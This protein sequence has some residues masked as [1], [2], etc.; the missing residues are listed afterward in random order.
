[1]FSVELDIFSGRPNPRWILS[2]AEEKELVN[3][4]L[5]DPAS[6]LPDTLGQARLGYRGFIVRVHDSQSATYQGALK[7]GVQVPLIF[8]IG[9]PAQ[10]LEGAHW[11][12]STAEKSIGKTD[13]TALEAAEA[14]LARA[15]DSALVQPPDPSQPGVPQ[16][17][18][19]QPRGA[20]QCCLYNYLTGTDYGFW[21][22]NWTYQHANNCYN[23][24]A[25]YR[26]GDLNVGFAQPGLQGGQVFGSLTVAELSAACRRDGW[27]DGCL[28]EPTIMVCYAIWPGQ[29]YHFW[30]VVA[31]SG[32]NVWGNKPGCNPAATSGDPSNP[33]NR[34]NYTT[35]GEYFYAPGSR[36]VQGYGTPPICR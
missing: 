25:N 7:S 12:L 2:E 18:T 14:E 15:E 36:V 5:A 28:S 24:A 17:S 9:T 20:G 6:I 4:I 23:F 21:N 22:S 32:S 16:P 30:R 33:A 29:D 1:M 27:S 19:P 3:R 10:A 26:V 8:R 11:L 35:F 31:I 13:A 34:G